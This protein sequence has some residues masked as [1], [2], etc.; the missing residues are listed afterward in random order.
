MLGILG[1]PIGYLLGSIP[2]GYLIS[3]LFG[4]KDIRTIGSGN[5]GATNVWRAAGPLAGMLVLI[6]DVGK[7]I[8]AVIIASLLSPASD[9]AEYF[10]L[11]SGL[12]AIGGHIFPIFLNF[13]GGKGV[14]TALGIML[15]LLPQETLLALAVFIIVVAISKYISL[16]SMIAGVAFF[17]ILVVEYLAHLAY[18]HPIYLPTS[19]LLALL[20][21]YTHRANIKRLLT[22]TE[23]HFSL[24]S[25]SSEAKNG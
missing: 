15:L 10:K 23:N 19:F 22:G 9:T 4:V 16:G 20:I 14:N 24:H 18:V 6:G 11:L 12:A 1:I 8:V 7:G 25:R 3:K 13:K 5:I 21:I 17:L 2:F